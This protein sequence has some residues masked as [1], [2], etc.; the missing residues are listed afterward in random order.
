MNR[1]IRLCLLPAVYSM[2][3]HSTFTPCLD[4]L[5]RR[6]ARPFAK[7]RVAQRE[8]RP[9]P[10]VVALSDTYTAPATPRYETLAKHLLPLLR[11]RLLLL[12]RRRLL[13]A[14]RKQ[15]NITAA[16]HMCLLQ[17]DAE[18]DFFL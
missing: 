10:S 17:V 11:L 9:T 8:G 4:G 13:L 16:A 6:F 1:A 12:L 18:Y 7:L 2:A 14:Q 3:Q 15:S 5:F